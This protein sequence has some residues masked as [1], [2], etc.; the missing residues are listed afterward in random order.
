M[1]RASLPSLPQ[2]TGSLNTLPPTHPLS[3]YLA[4]KDKI[5]KFLRKTFGE[6]AATDILS[7]IGYDYF[8]RFYRSEFEDQTDRITALN[9]QIDLHKTYIQQLEKEID[10]LKSV[11]HQT[12]I[13]HSND[14][15]K[16]CLDRSTL[17]NAAKD[18]KVYS[19][20][21]NIADE[22]NAAVKLIQFME[23]LD[24]TFQGYQ[25]DDRYKLAILK[26]K[27]DA[28]ALATITYAKPNTYDEALNVLR[29]RYLNNDR[30]G[31]SLENSLDK[32]TKMPEEHVLGFGY[33]IANL[34]SAIITIKGTSVDSMFDKLYKLFMKAFKDET[35][36]NH[37]VDRARASRNFNDLIV[38]VDRAVRDL[39]SLIKQKPQTNLDDQLL[40]IQ[41]QPTRGNYDN[42]MTNS[43]VKCTFCGYNNHTESNCFNKQ[44]A[45]QKFKRRAPIPPPKQFFRGQ[46]Q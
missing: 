31:L 13:P 37:L 5:H 7:G 1:S 18:I 27:L 16:G 25:L 14:N 30:C 23:Q 2:S 11:R 45:I 46:R 33:R 20:Q 41:N 19:G 39:P 24:N 28:D 44:R 38:A 35:R 22:V 42:R 12:N 26:R 6:Q 17:D 36:G 8:E 15:L 3:T 32:I 4:N 10:D 9:E 43:N 29:T 34:A 21:A 40:T